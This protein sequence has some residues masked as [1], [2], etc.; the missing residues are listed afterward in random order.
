MK[1]ITAA[2][3][4]SLTLSVAFA[5]EEA[6]P[7]PP[8]QAKLPPAEKIIADYIEASGG[9]A[10]RRKITSRKMTAM[11]RF[12]AHGIEAEVI[13]YARAPH[14]IYRESTIK[15]LGKNQAGS[16]GEVSWVIDLAT[17][18]Q[19][20]AGEALAFNLRMSKFYH[21]LD[22]KQHYKSAKTLGIEA[23]NDEPCYKVE[24]TPK[25]GDPLVNYYDQESKL[26]VR[27]DV[28]IPTP[29]G[30]IP[31]ESYMSE[32]K[33]FAGVK[34]PTK[35]TMKVFAQ[36]R[37]LEIKEIETNIEIPKGTFDVPEV[38]QEMIAMEKKPQPAEK[39]SQPEKPVETE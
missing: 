37:V 25:A 29:Q 30:K 8:P 36:E 35:T 26:L 31:V 32:F 5:E 14:F 17:G 3:V 9:E 19:I 1:C 2:L 4:L 11:L 7:T 38:I 20:L 10:A 16:N 34:V 6:K 27:T 18:P 24:L 22:W 28:A 33:E 21:E 12:P 13:E 39:D 23:V 15:G